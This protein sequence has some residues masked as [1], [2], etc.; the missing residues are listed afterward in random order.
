MRPPDLLKAKYTIKFSINIECL[1][2]LDTEC[3]KPT[4]CSI[5]VVWCIVGLCSTDQQYSEIHGSTTTEMFKFVEPFTITCN[6][7]IHLNSIRQVI[8][9][10]CHATLCL[11]NN[12][13]K[14]AYILGYDGV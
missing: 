3:A 6:F 13:L 1:T 12:I 2:D 9:H 14:R 8:I 11:Q 4:G 5:Q 7:I 10:Y